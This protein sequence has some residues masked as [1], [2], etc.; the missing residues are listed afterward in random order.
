M[1]YSTR[2]SKI[3][4]LIGLVFFST[5]IISF[6]ASS[7]SKDTTGNTALSSGSA[8]VKSVGREIADTTREYVDSI[9]S[10]NVS[11]FDRIITARG[12]NLIVKIKEI[13]VF[14][15]VYYWPLNV[16]EQRMPKGEIVEVIHKNGQRENFRVKAG[17]TQSEIK[18]WAVVIS[19]KDWERV[20]TVAEDADMTGLI[21]VGKISAK[22]EGSK[23]TAPSEYLEKNALII[24]KKKAPRLGAN[25][26]LI[27]DKKE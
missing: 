19:E 17:S 22:F 4:F 8:S 26:I 1:N 11:Q 16:V 27:T 21:E 15:V 14:E 20:I 18:D 23:I 13:N 25:V 24:L 7:V 12:E 9:T 3:L 10:V 6:S 5:T 2:I